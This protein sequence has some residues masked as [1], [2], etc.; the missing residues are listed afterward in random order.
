MAMVDMSGLG[1]SEILCIP[2]KAKMEALGMTEDDLQAALTASNVQLSSL[3]VVDGIYCY[4]V[5]FDSQVLTVDDV[6]NVYLNHE[7][8][9]LQLKDLCEIEVRTMTRQ[10]INRHEGKTVCRLPSLSRVMPKWANCEKPLLMWWMTC[11]RIT[12]N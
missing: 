3:S 8:R 6:R 7:G 9:L 10:N 12:L 11:K 4:H 2:D 5:H 1:N